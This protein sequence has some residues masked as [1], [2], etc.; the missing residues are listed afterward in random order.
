MRHTVRS[1]RKAGWCRKVIKGAQA[2]NGSGSKAVDQELEIFKGKECITSFARR[3]ENPM[4][5]RRSAW[6]GGAGA[7]E[8]RSYNKQ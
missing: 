4:N 1:A 3:D 7:K 5:K 2:E 6:R 8:K